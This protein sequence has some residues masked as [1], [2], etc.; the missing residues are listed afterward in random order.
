MPDMKLLATLQ[1]I[2]QSFFPKSL[3]TTKLLIFIT[4]SINSGKVS[5]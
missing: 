3:F 1:L 2:L 4:S 5:D